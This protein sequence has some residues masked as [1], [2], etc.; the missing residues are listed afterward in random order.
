TRFSRDW[1][2]DVCSSDLAGQLPVVLL[3]LGDETAVLADADIA[4]DAV[5][6]VV[7]ARDVGI[8]P[9]QARQPPL[10]SVRLAD[11]LLVVDALEE[12][13]GERHARRP[14][15]P[16]DLVQEAVRDKLEALLDELVVDLPLAF[17][18]FRSLE[19][20]GQAGLELAE[21]DVVEPGGVHVA[22]R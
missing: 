5:A 9:D 19:P 12:L 4:A 11:Q 7:L 13:A 3:I 20:G 10:A 14:A 1:S 17:D 15:A 16:L 8:E 22:A 21:A 18:L 2:S 6:A